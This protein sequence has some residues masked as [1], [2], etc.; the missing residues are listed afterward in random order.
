MEEEWPKDWGQQKWEIKKTSSKILT[1]LPELTKASVE[2]RKLLKHN[3]L[4]YNL[5][6]CVEKENYFLKMLPTKVDKIEEVKAM[7]I[8]Y[9]SV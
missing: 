2:Y 4:I 5:K 9:L 1:E 6:D 7:M 8:H 3:G